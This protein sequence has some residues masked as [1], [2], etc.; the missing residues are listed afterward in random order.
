MIVV[1][2]LVVDENIES[3]TNITQ[4]LERAQIGFPFIHEK[5]EIE[6][7]SSVSLNLASSGFKNQ[8]PDILILNANKLNISSEKYA[9]I[10][11]QKRNPSLITILIFQNLIPYNIAIEPIQVFDYLVTPFSEA[12]FQLVLNSAIKKYYLLLNFKNKN[13]TTGILEKNLHIIHELKTPVLAINGYL[14][15][16]SNA[17]LGNELRAYKHIIDRS[18]LRIDSLKLLIQKLLDQ[19]NAE[20]EQIENTFES[21][22]LL[23]LTKSAV[24]TFESLCIQKNV[25]IFIHSNKALNLT[26]NPFDIEVI[27]NNLLSNAI[28]YNIPNGEVSVQLIDN[29]NAVLIVVSDT[30]KGF[31]YN[32]LESKFE[33]NFYKK[34]SSSGSGFGLK[35]VKQIVNSYNGNVTCEQNIK[36]G[37]SFTVKLPKPIGIKEK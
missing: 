10:D 36:G 31:D 29:D 7:N 13:Q 2:I 12:N 6:W 3:I 22:D 18:I 33:L 28:K 1:R 21:F 19:S 27:L 4:V 32:L 26:A 23:E 17:S 37:T 5:F 24:E 14:Q 35:I 20:Y 16:L 11:L 34:Q 9:F 30:G 8:F 25:Q 15:M